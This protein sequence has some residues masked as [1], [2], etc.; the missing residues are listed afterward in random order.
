MV[1]HHVH[2]KCLASFVNQHHS[3]E[4]IRIQNKIVNTCKVDYLA[5]VDM[6]IFGVMR[7][8]T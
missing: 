6:R 1:V 8:N 2:V 3:A 5:N 7:L 4:D